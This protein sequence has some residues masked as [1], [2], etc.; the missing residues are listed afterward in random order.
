MLNVPRTTPS[1]WTMRL[2]GGSSGLGSIF[3]VVAGGGLVVVSSGGVG[4]GVVA[5]TA[6]GLVGG[7]AA[8]TASVT[9]FVVAGGG[10]LVGEVDGGVVGVVVATVA[11]LSSCFKY[12]AATYADASAGASISIQSPLVLTSLMTSPFFKKPSTL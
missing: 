4:V 9:V 2:G 10:S 12:C 5:A 8:V 11:G 6:G 7:A 3:S 1:R